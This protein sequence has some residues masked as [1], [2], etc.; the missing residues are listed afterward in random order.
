WDVTTG[1]EQ[2][3]LEGHTDQVISVAFSPDGRRL[4]SAGLDKTVKLWDTANRKETCTFRGH[5][6]WA[7]HVA[8]SPDGQ[9]LAS[10]SRDGTVKLWDVGSTSQEYRQFQWPTAAVQQAVFSPDGRWLASAN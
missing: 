1:R 3:R 4:A 5:Q 2:A 6:D 7:L 9:L 10:S 8:F